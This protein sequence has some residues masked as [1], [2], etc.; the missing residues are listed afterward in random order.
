MIK[1]WELY[2]KRLQRVKLH[3]P[4]PIKNRDPNL[5]ND[6]ILVNSQAYLKR[7]KLEKYIPGE[8]VAE[9]DDEILKKK[10]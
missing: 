6:S 2:Y 3:K 4:K 5:N 9:D 7:Y 8:E 10:L 1:E